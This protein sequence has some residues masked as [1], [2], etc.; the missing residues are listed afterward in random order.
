[1]E[2]GERVTLSG[3]K[4]E[5]DLHY[6]RSGRDI[7]LGEIINVPA[8]HF[9]MM[10]DNTLGSADSRAWKSIKIGIDEDQNIV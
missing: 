2:G 3:I 1:M 5:R 7:A 4:I 6:T 10:G 9:F 8:G